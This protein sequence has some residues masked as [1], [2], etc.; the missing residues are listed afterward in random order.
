MN[1]LHTTY[2]GLEL[3]NPLIAGASPMTATADGVRRLEDAGAAAVVMHS[4][5]EE[6]IAA[7]AQALEYFLQANSESYAE[8]LGFFP[9]AG[10]FDNINAEQHLKELEKIKLAVGIPVIASINGA[11]PGGWV[12]YVKRF[13]MAGAD[14][15][16]LNITYIP[17]SLTMDGRDV[18]QRYIDI[19]RDVCSATELPVSVKMNA[20]FSA[21]A[22]MAAQLVEAGASGLVLFDNPIRVDIDLEQLSPIQRANI[23]GSHSLSETL[24]WNAILYGKL[25]ASLCASTGVHSGEDAIKALMSGSDAVQM[26]SALLLNGPGHITTVLREMVSWMEEK[27]YDSVAQMR[28]SISLGH[29]DNPDAYERSSYMRALQTY[30]R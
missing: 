27:E 28:G 1:H 22:Q 23:T 2:L 30:R 7:E 11:T 6:Q 21:P 16:E 8:S 14:A 26:A 29:T 9:E 24:R 13:E 20:Y 15:V 25:H 10:S 3:K 12:E 19:V 18:E 17:T 4:L 5:F